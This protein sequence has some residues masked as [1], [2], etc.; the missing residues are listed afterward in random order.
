MT[1]EERAELKSHLK[2]R[3]AE[4][5]AQ[6]ESQKAA[7]RPVAPDNAIGRLTRMDAIQSQEIDKNSYRQTQIQLVGLARALSHI[8]DPDFGLC[9]ECGRP[10]AFGRLKAMPGS[11]CCVDCA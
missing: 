5:S 4:L 2:Q 8:D 10:I 7:S 3:S 11:T 1:P 9:S 6:S